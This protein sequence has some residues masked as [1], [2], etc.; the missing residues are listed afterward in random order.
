MTTIKLGN[1]DNL[2][3]SDDNSNGDKIILGNGANDSVSA[4][5]S[6]Y[7]TI[8]LGSGAGDT[9]SISASNPS[10]PFG[11]QYDKITLG[12]GNNRLGV[13]GCN[14]IR[15]NHPRQWRRRL[16]EHRWIILW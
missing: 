3:V 16:G 8:I 4:D 1:G 5:V 11:G 7:D 9:V 2:S 10:A 12:N 6:Q 13:R 14:P 15:H